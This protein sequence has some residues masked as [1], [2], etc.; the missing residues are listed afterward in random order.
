MVDMSLY[1]SVADE[2]VLQL[3]C[4]DAFLRSQQH[5]ALPA[6]AGTSVVFWCSLL[7]PSPAVKIHLERRWRRA[8]VPSNLRLHDTW[9]PK[10]T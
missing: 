8:Q 6:S 4:L 5:V 1:S 3:E 7:P 9:T 10:L 2:F